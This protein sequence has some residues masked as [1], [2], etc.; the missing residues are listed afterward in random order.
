MAS[1]GESD[2][3][4]QNFLRQFLT[5]RDL[6]LCMDHFYPQWLQFNQQDPRLNLV[7]GESEG[8]LMSTDCFFMLQES[9][10]KTTNTL[11]EMTG[12]KMT[13]SILALTS[14]IFHTSLMESTKSPNLMPSRGTSSISGEIVSFLEKMLKIMH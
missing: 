8:L 14:P 3:I 1:G 9:N 4:S 13:R 10:F 6:M 7:I 11:L 5:I 2:T 12:S